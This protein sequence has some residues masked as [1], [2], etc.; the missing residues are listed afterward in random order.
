[1]A[2]AAPHKRFRVAFSFAEETREF[3]AEVARILA[4][5]FGKEAIFYDKF[6][7]WEFVR[8]DGQ[9]LVGDGLGYR[10]YTIYWES[11]LIV[12]VFCPDYDKQ[13]WAGIEWF[14]IYALPEEIT[15]HR[16]MASRFGHAPGRNRQGFIELDD[17][18]PEQFATLILERLAIHEGKP[19][20]HYTT[21]PSTTPVRPVPTSIQHN[22]PAL[23]SQHR[24]FLCYRRQDTQ[25]HTGRLRDRLAGIYGSEGVFMDVDDVPIGIDFVDY[26]EEVLSTVALMVVLIGPSWLTTPDRRG[27]RK[28]DQSDDLVRGEIASALKRKIPVIPVLVEDAIMPDSDDVPK[29]IRGLTRRNAIELTHRRWDS[30][31]Q[32]VLLAVEKLMKAKSGG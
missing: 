6:H 3:V 28:L 10:L 14:L 20:D 7:P 29:D 4:D 32:R 27:R 17:K 15:E 5:R 13:R 22:P 30:D 18:T 26:I 16:L 19:K 11:D 31:V 2:D 8:H 9:A 23:P 21:P 25:G 1:M 12:S 24:V